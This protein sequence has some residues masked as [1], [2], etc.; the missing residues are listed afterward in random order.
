MFLCDSVSSY[1]VTYL[2]IGLTL[3]YFMSSPNCI[4]SLLNCG[5]LL[6]HLMGDILK[7]RT[8][9]NKSVIDK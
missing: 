7:Q 2:Y 3:I 5:Q 4:V 9:L 6:S 8:K 1:V